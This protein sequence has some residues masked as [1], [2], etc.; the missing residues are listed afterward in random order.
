MKVNLYFAVVCASASLFAQTPSPVKPAAPKAAAPARPAG[1]ASRPA[2]KPA[3]SAQPK[4]AVKVTMPVNPSAEK[5]V[6]TIGDEKVTAAE[7][8]NF[9]QILPE[10][11]RVQKRQ[12]AEQMVRVKLLADEARKRGLDKDKMVQARIKFQIDNMLA[13]ALFADIQGGAKTDDA[14]VKKYYDEHQ[15]EYESVAARHILVKFKGSP[16]PQREGK[17]ELTEEEALVKAQELRKRIAAGEDFAK[18]AKEESDDTGSGANGGELGGLFKRG[19]MVPAFE[20]AAFSLPVGQVSEPIKTQFGYHLIKVE[21]KESK[22]F[23]EAR[24][25]IEKSLKPDVAK[26]VVEDIRKQAKVVM[27]DAYFGAE[28]KP[29]TP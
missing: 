4:P 18:L 3:D 8:E 29:K 28:E 14:A 10:Q 26:Q 23:E 17:K 27:D 20:Q 11:Y 22:N 19:S 2:P 9:M 5:V 1:S 13:G 25:D 24:P 21:K 6:L 16:V 15:K 7:F 12:V